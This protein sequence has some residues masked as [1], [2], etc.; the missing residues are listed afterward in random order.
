M[1]QIISLILS[2]CLFTTAIPISACAEEALQKKY[3]DVEYGDTRK[4]IECI[5]ANDTVFCSGDVL[6]EITDYTFY[7]IDESQE[8]GFVR[9]YDNH[10]SDPT[11]EIQTEVSI[12]VDEEKHK[13]DVTA[14]HNNYTVE[15][16]KEN[17]EVYL[18][19]EDIVYLLHG[20][21]VLLPDH[22]YIEAMPYNIID[23]YASYAA[24]IASLASKPEDALI[25]TGWWGSKTKTGQ[26]VYS[27]IAEMLKDF[28]GNLLVLYDPDKGHV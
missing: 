28:D 1:K 10:I 3:I 12:V 26:A 2:I 14:M 7:Q 23:F 20:N 16:Y 17:N 25:N 13:A 5:Y 27:T 6:A 11:L 22:I 8:C 15:C 9:E 18:P 19:M 4:T 24:D 21:L